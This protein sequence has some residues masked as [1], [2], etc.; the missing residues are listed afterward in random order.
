MYMIMNHW[1]ASNITILGQ[2]DNNNVQKNA[3]KDKKKNSQQL[4]DKKILKMQK[5]V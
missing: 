2:R 5:Q 4:Y 3:L 1:L